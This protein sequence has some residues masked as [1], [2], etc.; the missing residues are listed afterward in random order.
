M[1]LRGVPEV[2]FFSFACFSFLAAGGK[3][4]EPGSLLKALGEAGRQ[5]LWQREIWGKKKKSESGRECFGGGRRL[6]QGRCCV[7]VC[8]YKRG[9]GGGGGAPTNLK[10]RIPAIMN[11]TPYLARLSRGP[12]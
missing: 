4:R 12:E 3:E 5:Q 2:L 11:T 1:A 6:V 8:V 7:R 9:V 10:L